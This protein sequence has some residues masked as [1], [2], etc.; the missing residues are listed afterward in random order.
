MHGAPILARTSGPGSASSWR[1]TIIMGNNASSP[2]DRRSTAS[3]RGPAHWGSA[4]AAVNMDVMGPAGTLGWADSCNTMDSTMDTTP[5]SG[6]EGGVPLTRRLSSKTKRQISEEEQEFFDS[7]ELNIQRKQSYGGPIPP[8]P[9]PHQW[10]NFIGGTLNSVSR[11]H[12]PHYMFR[13]VPYMDMDI[14][15]KHNKHLNWGA[16]RPAK[17]PLKRRNSSSSVELCLFIDDLDV[18]AMIK[19]TSLV[20][21]HHISEG[22]AMSWPIDP[23]FNIFNDPPGMEVLEFYSYVFKTAQ[24]EKDCV[25]M[26]LVYI[27]R[28]LTETAGKLRIFRK[29]WRSVVLCGLILAS[30]IWDDLSMWNCDFS[31][32]G[33]CSL[34]RINELEV[35]VLQVLQYNVRVASS[36]FASYYFRMRHWCILLG[37]E[38]PGLYDASPPRRRSE[39]FKAT[40]ALAIEEAAARAAAAARAGE[41]EALR[42]RREAAEA[43]AALVVEEDLE[44]LG[45]AGEGGRRGGGAVV[46]GGKERDNLLQI[47]GAT[48][49][50]EGRRARGVPGIS[51]RLD[52][53]VYRSCY[54]RLP[55]SLEELVDM[56]QTDAGGRQGHYS[57]KRCCELVR[58]MLS[59]VRHCHAHGLCHRDLKLENWVFESDKPDAE[60]KLIDFGLST[61]FGKD[62]VMHVPVGTPYSIAPE[63]LTGGY[64]LQCDVW[65]VGVLAFMMLAGK[66]PFTGRDDFEVLEAVKA[67]T[68]EWPEHVSV[69]EEAKAFVAGLLVVDPAQRLTCEQALKHRWMQSTQ[70]EVELPNPLVMDSLQSFESLGTIKKLVLRMIAFTLEAWQVESLRCEFR[71]CDR[72][73]N[74]LITLQELRVSL[75]QQ[76]LLSNGR[77]AVGLG[78]MLDAAQ[79]GP[80]DAGVIRYNDFLAASLMSS[81]D[82]SILDDAILQAAF[83]RFDRSQAGEITGRDLRLFLGKE[84]DDNEIDK[85]LKEAGLQHGGS[86]SFEEFKELMQTTLYS[87]TLS[88]AGSCPPPDS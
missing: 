12:K 19:V 25:I 85:M 59:A 67:G 47:G 22:C 86:M 29:N 36:L 17:L 23:R 46:G 63:C 56:T 34:R 48:R 73:C 45:G 9:E 57:E 74:G 79:G 42:V 13:T 61:Y 21:H 51:H 44:G 28:V 27:E 1:S 32:V 82:N 77:D 64:T 70:S 6:E 66:P 76:G 41:N 65:S 53:R 54:S 60:L 16:A 15:H 80:G 71:K 39:S 4:E 10:T 81:K 37:V 68:W 20:L 7:M 40:E 83:D 87:P 69:S 2:T 24:L 49:A 52:G 58:K 14:L 3:A 26:S 84:L 5:S 30:K 72:A 8:E 78:K 35:A 75:A 88:R 50:P 43:A 55:P 62:E 11:E 18:Q 31:K 38:T 33:R